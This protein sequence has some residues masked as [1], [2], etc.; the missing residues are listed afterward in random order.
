MHC[1]GAHGSLAALSLVFSA[2]ETAGVLNEESQS[3]YARSSNFNPLVKFLKQK[4]SKV[5][6]VAIYLARTCPRCKHYLDIVIPRGSAGATAQ[7][8]S[9]VCLCCPY[10][11]H[12]K[13]IPGRRR[14]HGSKRP[15]IGEARRRTLAL[16]KPGDG[17]WHGMDVRG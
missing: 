9:A 12:W 13:L 5:L 15:A 1:R 17:A 14:H 3:T 7:T 16:I 2:V 11:L 10:Q 4:V 8:I 6:G